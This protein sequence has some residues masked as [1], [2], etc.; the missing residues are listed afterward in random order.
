M[1][2]P[3]RLYSKTSRIVTGRRKPWLPTT[4]D[5]CVQ[6]A[7]TQG[8]DVRLF[9]AMPIGKAILDICLRFLHSRTIIEPRKRVTS[10]TNC[11]D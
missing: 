10:L 6:T 1:L 3:W 4:G 8:N 5:S 2:H 11:L 9:M 7:L